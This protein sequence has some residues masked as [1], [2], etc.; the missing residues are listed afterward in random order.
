[1]VQSL[2][3]PGRWG[4]YSFIT[5]GI[6]DDEFAQKRLEEELWWTVEGR[7]PVVRCGERVD[8]AEGEWAEARSGRG[9][10]EVDEVSGVGRCG[11]Q[12]PGRV[13]GSPR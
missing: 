11:V 4:S 1:M 12:V 13:S 3:C 10:S 9:S 5:I 7:E 2:S 8:N 6:T